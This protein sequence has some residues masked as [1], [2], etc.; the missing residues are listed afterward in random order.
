MLKSWKFQLTITIII[1]TIAQL[2]LKKAANNSNVDWRI[3]TFYWMA[4]ALFFCLISLIPLRKYAVKPNKGYIGAAIGGIMCACSIAVASILYAIT[5]A[6]K[7]APILG[8][9]TPVAGVICLIVLKEKLTWK[10]VVATILACVC[11][12]CLV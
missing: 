12:I 4:G 9:S 3:N 8:L 1:W 5:D 11:V 6:S 2:L 7:I 10:L